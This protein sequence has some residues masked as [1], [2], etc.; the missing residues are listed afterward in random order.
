MPFNTFDIVL[1][2]ARDMN[3][4]ISHM[5]GVKAAV[6]ATAKELAAKAKAELAN[7][8]ETGTAKITVSH[9]ATDSYVNLDDPAALAI[10]YGHAAYDQTK[11][12]K[13]GSTYTQRV[14]ASKGLHILGGLI[15]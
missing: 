4:R 15:P 14:G 1:I 3:T 9:G 10:E 7:H 12:R 5:A 2:P 8:R 13:D 11:T 6:R